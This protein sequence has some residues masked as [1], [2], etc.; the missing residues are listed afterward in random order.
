MQQLKNSKAPRPFFWPT[1]TSKVLCGT[2][3][4]LYQLG[5]AYHTFAILAKTFGSLACLNFKLFL[6]RRNPYLRMLANHQIRAAAI[7]ST[8]QVLDLKKKLQIDARTNNKK[9]LSIKVAINKYQ[10][11]GVWGVKSPKEFAPH[12]GKQV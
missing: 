11:E 8:Y 4:L 1:K 10:K 3:I 5:K 7:R 12:L 6:L 9:G 2:L